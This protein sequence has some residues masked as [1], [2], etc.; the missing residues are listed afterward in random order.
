MRCGTDMATHDYGRVCSLNS[1]NLSLLDAASAIRSGVL[2]PVEY[3]SALFARMDQIEPG[4]QAW[5]T[6]DRDAVLSEARRCEAEARTGQFRG[7]L[8]G[9]PVGIKDIFLTKG[10][11][12]TMGSRLF[13]D[14]IPEHD[15]RAV[16][17]L[18]RAGAIVLGKTVTTLFANLD[19]GP[20]RNPWNP[21][22]TPGGSSSGSAAAVAARMCPAAIGSQTVGS[23]GR[24]AAFCGVAS[25]VPPQRRISL[26]NVFPLAWSLDHVG[27]FARCAADLELMRNVMGESQVAQPASRHKFRIGV[28]RE[29]FYEHATAE[30]RSLS[31]RLA[32][33]LGSSGF[34]IDEARLPP[35]FGRHQEILRTILQSE[36]A[37]IHRRRFAESPEAYGPKIRSLIEAGLAVQA[38]DYVHAQRMR[39]QYQ[40]DMAKLF[41]NF[42]V[43]MTP[44]AP[45][46]APEGIGSTGDPVMNG[47]WTLTDFPTMTLPH[48]L[49][50]NG[51]PI[52]V[53]LTAL[54]EGLLQETG[55]AIEAVIAFKAQP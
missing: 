6:V 17:R 40:H 21:E 52:G 37:T 20:T 41:A 39:R 33:A 30:A 12:T 51:L 48:T 18:K 2:S 47:P 13:G 23:V 9:V 8:H 28:V 45:G 38:V 49:G 10:L 16:T 1:E 34:H 4:I 36:T 22:H 53:Q 7:P 26:K 11:R 19:P 31:D 54:H 42:D 46:T 5:T 55:K 35:I 25:L 43:L 44:P 24:P 3:A 27:I 14:Y 32:E 50:S 15:A 29:F